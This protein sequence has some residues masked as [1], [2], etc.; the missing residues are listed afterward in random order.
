MLTLTVQKYYW[1]KVIQILDNKSLCHLLFTVKDRY[2]GAYWTQN[3][4]GT[5][6]I[7]IENNTTCLDTGQPGTV[8]KKLDTRQS[9]I[10]T[11]FLEIACLIP[12]RT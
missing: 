12:L 6:T 5:V 1:G 9:E 10:L 11:N 3:T 2:S 4:P 7:L 8:Y